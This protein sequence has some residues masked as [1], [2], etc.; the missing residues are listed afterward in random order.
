MTPAE[1]A[2]IAAEVAARRA[3]LVAPAKHGPRPCAYPPCGREFVP[4]KHAPFQRYCCPTHR[5]NDYH[6]RHR[7]PRAVLANGPAAA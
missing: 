2:W 3:A 7:V 4:S 5:T 6:R 1:R